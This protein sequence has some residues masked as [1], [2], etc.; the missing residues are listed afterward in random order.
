VQG[1]ITVGIIA[2]FLSYSRQFSRPL[3]DLANT[4]NTLQ[5]AIAGAERVF[6]IQDEKEETEDLTRAEVLKSP[7][8]HVIFE[9]VSFGYREDVK[10]LKDISFEAVEGSSIA[11]VGPT[12]AGKTTIVNLLTRF[13]DVSSGTIFIDGEDI[14]KY[15]RDSL[16]KC[17]GI[18]LQDTYLFSGTINENIKYGKLSA[19]Q[20]E[21]VSAARMANADVFIQRLPKGYDT[22]LAESGNNLSQGQRQLLA[23]ARAIQGQNFTYRRLWLS[24]CRDE[25][26]L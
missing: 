10:I 12:G 13:Y 20:E 8:G 22:I 18:V 5:S 2:S 24:L 21:I 11:L 3:N 19:T 17:F 7:R 15:T 1:S 16:R 4:F 25:Q 26:A 9:N 14:R 6:E 23:I